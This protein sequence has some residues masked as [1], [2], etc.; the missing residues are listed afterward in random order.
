[1]SWPALLLAPLLALLE[2]ALAYALSTPLCQRQMGPWLHLVPAVS[3][4]LVLVC[5]ALALVDWRRRAGQP[6]GRFISGVS[7]GMGALCALT[8]AAMWVPIGWLSPC[9]G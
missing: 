9:A 5:S 7:L 3:L 2:Q 4:V 8:I 6:A 1:M